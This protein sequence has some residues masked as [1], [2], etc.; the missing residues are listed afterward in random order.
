MV[1]E[2]E[3]VEEAPDGDEQEP[4]HEDDEGQLAEILKTEA[5]A[6]AAELDEAAD[7]GVDHETLQEVEETVESAAEALVTM[8]E[9]RSRLAE[10]RKDR[11]YG[12]SSNADPKAK[13]N[14]QKKLRS[15][16]FDCGQPGHWAG[17]AECKK[18]GMKLGRKAKQVQITE[19]MTTEHYIPDEGDVEKSNEV[20]A[21]TVQPLAETVVAALE[22]SH[23]QP[24]E[25]N[26]ASIGLT[27]DKRLVGALDSA[28]N[29]TCT[30]PEWLQGYLKGH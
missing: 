8:K 23:K 29:R 30:G 3:D 25:V 13:S 20:L 24:K 7:Q 22:A 28:C 21:V 12:K 18:P 2:H 26:L 15:N 10:V 6:L 17:D 5:E 14:N 1:S 16:C 9:A 11:G 19:A 27:A 4:L